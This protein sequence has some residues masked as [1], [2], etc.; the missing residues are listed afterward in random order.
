M[1]IYLGVNTVKN[2]FLFVLI[3]LSLFQTACTKNG[4]AGIQQILSSSKP[5]VG[6]VFEISSGDDEGLK[7]LNW[8][9]EKCNEW[10]YYRL[11]DGK[12]GDQKY[13]D[14]WPA[15]FNNVCVLQHKG[16]GLAIWNIVQY[17]ITNI[18][19]RIHVDGNP[20]VFY[21]FHG[22]HLLNDGNY[23]LGA[24]GIY[25][26]SNENQKIIYKPYIEEIKSSIMQVRNKYPE[27]DFGFKSK[28]NIFN[29]IFNKIYRGVF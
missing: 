22:F 8:W 14:D 3:G 10:C 28:E 24:N 1:N 7:C 15:R 16:A 2:I 29:K 12:L 21:H 19:G 23:E 5:P 17:K 6:V 27:F 4:E 20:L 25:V 11:E 26:L 13:L 18:N 9:R